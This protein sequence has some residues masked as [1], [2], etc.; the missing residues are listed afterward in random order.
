MKTFVYGPAGSGKTSRGLQRL[1]DLIQFPTGGVLV[2]VPQRTLAE[3]YYEL[4]RTL[5]GGQPDVLTIGGLSRRMVDL[6]WPMVA[7]EAG[8]AQPSA[9]PVFLNLET[10]Q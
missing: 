6:F 5:A 3:P 4:I 9:P 7:E 10:S 2:Y 1:D 8:F